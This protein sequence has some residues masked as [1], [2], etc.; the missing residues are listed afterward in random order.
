MADWKGTYRFSNNTVEESSKN[1]SLVT[2]K[3]QKRE[4][5]RQ[6]KL[7]KKQAEDDSF[8]VQESLQIFL[9]TFNSERTKLENGLSDSVAVDRVHLT[10]H[11]DQL[12]HHVTKLQRYVSESAM[13]LPPYELKTAQNVLMS[14]QG[15]IQEKRDE[16][17]PKK[18]FAFKSNRKTEKKAAVPCAVRS[19]ETIKD[20]KSEDDLVIEHAACKFIGAFNETL[21]KEADEIN[22][23]DVALAG[24]T[25]CTVLLCG[26]P[27][28]I[29][30]NKL[31]NCK[32]FCGPVP[33]SIF[34][35]E[36]SNCTFVLA[37]Q[38]LRIHSTTESHFYIHV[39]SKAIIEDCN[40]VKF[41][42]YNWS[43][44][45][46]DKHYQ[47]TGL[48]KVRNNWDKVDDF[49]WLAADAHSPNWSILEEEK[50]ISSWNV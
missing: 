33:G 4:D 18:K 44:E 19:E 10:E 37:C 27:S 1:Q 36:C 26:A 2:E 14:L 3:L 13:F 49:N 25:E 31:K 16:M 40:T 11:F 32:I 23:K 22:K 35:R 5:E 9:D 8:K 39:T 46:L 29:H 30:I 12:S 6:E 50:R 21:R 41:A 17:L 42:P 38:Q 7:R 48:S 24:L 47:A 45:Q 28:A 15:K 34:I 43:Y 20:S